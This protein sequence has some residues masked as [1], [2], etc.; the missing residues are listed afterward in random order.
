M[1]MSPYRNTSNL[2]GAS[3]VETEILALGLCNDRLSKAQDDRSRV[4]A[5]S[6]NH[7][8]W[9]MFL[10][11]LSGDNNRLPQSVKD[12]LIQLGIWSMAYCNL[13]LTKELPLKPL[14]EVNRNIQE[15]LRLQASRTLSS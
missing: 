12:K 4:E 9:A 10:R 7:A 11:D 3:P 1:S 5:L 15:G 8:L 14:I 2:G 13:A 6:R